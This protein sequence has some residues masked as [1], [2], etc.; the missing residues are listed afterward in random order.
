MSLI[1]KAGYSGF[2]TTLS[3]VVAGVLENAGLHVDGDI[4]HALLSKDVV[5]DLI[6]EQAVDSACCCAS[7]FV[8]ILMF[9]CSVIKETSK[10]TKTL[11]NILHGTILTKNG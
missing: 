1:P 7:R 3:I 11:Q 2:A 8:R 4:V 9:T 6:N 5:K 10:E